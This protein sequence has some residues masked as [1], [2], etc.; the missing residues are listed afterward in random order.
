MQMIQH[1]HD[2]KGMEYKN[3]DGLD[4]HLQF[5]IHA[6]TNGYITILLLLLQEFDLKS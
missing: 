2:A 6:E 3:L 1:K 4:S 5:R